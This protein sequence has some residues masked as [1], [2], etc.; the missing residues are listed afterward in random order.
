MPHQCVRCGLKY[1]DASASLLKG[2]SCGSRFFFFYK[3]EKLNKDE[4]QILKELEGLSPKQRENIEQEIE[5]DV[6]EIIDNTDEKPV[7]LD[8]ESVRVIKPGKFEI[9][10]LNLFKRKPIIYKIADGKYIIDLASTFQLMNK[11][12][13]K[14]KKR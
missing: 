1:P 11:D 9:D 13:N 12:K 7:I 4:E 14:K 2:C 6:Q 3:E 5:T 10:L 8:L